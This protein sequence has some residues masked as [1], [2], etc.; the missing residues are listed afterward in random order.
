MLFRIILIA[1]SSLLFASVAF[2]QA[3]PA[4]VDQDD[5]M[6]RDAP[7]SASGIPLKR[8]TAVQILE[9]KEDWAK[10]S[11]TGWIRSASLKAAEDKSAGATPKVISPVEVVS[12]AIEKLPASGSKLAQAQIILKIKNNLSIPLAGWKGVL[13]VQKQQ[14]GVLFSSAV[15][16]DRPFAAGSTAEVKYYWEDGEEQYS[17]LISTPTEQIRLSLMRIE[18]TK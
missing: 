16:D 5:Q 12:F 14:G 7:G 2:A 4:V 15:S 17:S 8:G 6:L 10:I 18:I 3:R 11:I 9:T 13:V 1:L